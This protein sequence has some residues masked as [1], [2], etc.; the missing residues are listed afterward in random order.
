MSQRVTKPVL[1]LQVVNH[2][3]QTCKER[4]VAISIDFLEGP[5]KSLCAP[6]CS[7]QFPDIARLAGFVSKRK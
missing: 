1:Y 4:P 5:S 2:G 3:C 6:C 7:I